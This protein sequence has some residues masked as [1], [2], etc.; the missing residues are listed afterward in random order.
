MCMFKPKFLCQTELRRQ[1]YDWIVKT[2]MEQKHQT[3]PFDLYDDNNM[4]DSVI[5]DGPIWV[6]FDEYG[7]LNTDNGVDRTYGLNIFHNDLPEILQ[8]AFPLSKRSV[9]P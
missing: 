8:R 5:S 4:V 9:N 2:R 6:G 3:I 7:Q 1:V